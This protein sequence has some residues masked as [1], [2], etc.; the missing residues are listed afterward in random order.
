MVLF[1][2]LNFIHC[3]ILESVLTL[4]LALSEVKALN[5]SLDKNCKSFKVTSGFPGL[6]FNHNDIK[7]SQ[8]VV[9][10]SRQ[11]AI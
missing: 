10:T 8:Q 11:P 1:V 5:K 9:K 6:I 7:H 2:F 3:V 4:D